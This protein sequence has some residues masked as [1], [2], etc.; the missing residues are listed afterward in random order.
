VRQGEVAVIKDN[1]GN[2]YPDKAETINGNRLVPRGYSGIWN[3]ALTPDTYYLNPLAY[4]GILVKTTQR[5]YTYQK[6]HADDNSINIRSKDGFTIAAD[7]RVV[8]VV[9]PENAPRVVALHGDPDRVVKNIQ[10]DETLEN[11]EAQGVLPVV[12]AEVR[13]IGEKINAFDLINQR[14]EKETE[15]S[16]RVKAKL[17]AG[18]LNVLA[19][20]LANVDLTVTE[21]GRN[22]L[23]TQT[24]KKIAEERIATYNQQKLAEETRKALV[25]A[26]TTA[27][28]EKNLVQAQ[29]SILINE[30]AGKAQ[31]VLADYQRQSY[32][33]V[34]QALGVEN[35][36]KL[37]IIRLAGEKNV[38]I[39]PQVFLGTDPVTAVAGA[40][41]TP[42]K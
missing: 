21:A 17:E 12:R 23:Q 16:A 3:V 32:E 10:E 37:E 14:S 38:I 15:L 29:R 34:V 31:L 36:A 42:R 28:T 22:L 41:L 20:Y 9:T 30:Q 39:T 18:Y 27:D 26:E 24:D 19:F 11:L 1:T 13:N 5:V 33:K 2:P 8:A 35:A 4:T 25:N 40:L 6:T 7:V